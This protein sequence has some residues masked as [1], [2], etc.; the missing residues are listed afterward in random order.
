MSEQV[1]E[2]TGATAALRRGWTTGACATAATKAAWTALLTGAFPDPVEILLPKGE[3]PAF[4]LAVERR[5]R[6]AHGDWAEAGIVK[7]AGD[8]PD[9]THQAMIVAR[10]RRGAPGSGVVFRAGEGVGTITKAGLPL[11]PG[12]PAINPVPRRLMQA[13][14]AEVAAAQGVAGDVE[15][16]ISVPGGEDLA[17]QTWNPRLGILGGLSILGTTGIVVPFSCSAWIHSIQRGVD[18]ARAAGLAHVAGC[19]GSTSEGV[20]Q[21]LYGLPEL[22]LLDMGD[23]AGALL[24]YLRR[25]PVPRLTIGGGFAKLVKLA[26]GQM[27]LHSGRSQ[28]DADVLASWLGEAGGSNAQVKQARGANTALEVLQIAQ[29]T[30]LRLGDLVARRAADAAASLVAPAAIAIDVVAV[31]RAGTIVGRYGV[32]RHG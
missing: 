20:V 17:K 25:H 8:D 11:P 14:I 23:F 3:R 18:V 29:A 6:D 9:V 32:G 16:E 7:D 12:E 22:A 13:V 26:Q 24:K 30:G 4:A 1:A 27:D 10:L 19:T 28:V 2:R 5:G 15:I 31:D 21:Q